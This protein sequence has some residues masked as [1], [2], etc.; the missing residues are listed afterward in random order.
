MVFENNHLIWHTPGEWQVNQIRLADADNNGQTELLLVIW[1]KGSF[2]KSKPFWF[3]GFDDKYTCHLFL[4]R[5]SMAFG[6]QQ[7]FGAKSTFRCRLGQSNT[8]TLRPVIE[9]SNQTARLFFSLFGNNQSKVYVSI[10][11]TLL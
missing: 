10:T 1:K 8:P 3:K 7:A 11:L 5:R 6:G 2:G 9:D 4:Y